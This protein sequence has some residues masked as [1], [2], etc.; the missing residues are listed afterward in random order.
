MMYDLGSVVLRKPEP[1]DL[2]ALYAQKNNAAV[3]MAL[4]GFTTGYAMADLRQWVEA[5]R[6]RTDEVLWVIAETGTNRCLGHVGLYR[7]DYRI[8]SA[9]FA[10]MLGEPAFRGQGIGKRCTR[11]MLEYGFRE[12]NLNRVDLSVLATN[13]RAIG[14]YE[15]LGFRH[16]GRL[17][18][19]QFRSGQYVDVLL[20]AILAKEYADGH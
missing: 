12:L 2:A 5:H 6:T 8:R 10:I 16:E 7:I 9:E 14:L 17:R 4:G 15:S 20:M 1:E 3:R 18:E 13:E 19:A 11:F